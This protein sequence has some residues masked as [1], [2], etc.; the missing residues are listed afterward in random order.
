MTKP[1]RC[2]ALDHAR[3]CLRPACSGA[4]DI[5]VCREHARL[6]L[7]VLID[8]MLSAPTR[9]M[10]ARRQWSTAAQ[11]QRLIDKMHARRAA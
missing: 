5:F 11:G 2:I 4:G 7:M 6:M 8:D 1:P 10:L 3:R 9:A